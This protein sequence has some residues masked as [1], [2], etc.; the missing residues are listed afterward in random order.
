MSSL[1]KIFLVTLVV[2]AA[3]GAPASASG[4]VSCHTINAKGIGQD[5]GGGQ[6]QADILGGGLLQGTTE[7]TLT[8]T[9]FSGTVATFEGTIVFTVNNGTLTAEL[10]GT[11]D[12]ATGAFSAT[13][14]S[15]SGTGKLAGATGALSFSGIEN[16]ADGTFTEDISGE[17]CADLA[18]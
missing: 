6:T 9:G 8:I 5:L 11:F 17:I 2:L 4:V 16:L 15:M 7:A 14:T 10:S 3:A 1:R 18:P 12:V 13:T